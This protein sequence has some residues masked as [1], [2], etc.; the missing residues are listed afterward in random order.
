VKFFDRDDVKKRII[1]YYSA[2]FVELDNLR[3]FYNIS[4]P[5]PETVIF[6]H[7]HDPIPWGDKSAPKSLP[8]SGPVVRLYNTGGW[9]MREEGDNKVFCG[10]E[11]FKYETGKGFYSISIR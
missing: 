4:L 5:L 8:P 6:G 7:T 3:R 2:S 9:L 1:D 11:V 10:A